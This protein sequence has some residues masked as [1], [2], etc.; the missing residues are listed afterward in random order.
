MVK[1][2]VRSII[3]W[4]AG[5]LCLIAFCGWLYVGCYNWAVKIDRGVKVNPVVSTAKN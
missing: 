5:V 4:F 3:F 2:F 1:W